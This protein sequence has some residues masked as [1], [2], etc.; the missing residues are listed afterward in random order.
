[1]NKKR[2]VSKIRETPF[3]KGVGMDKIEEFDKQKTK[4][5]KYIL[6]KKRSES[7]IRTKFSHIIDENMLEDI[8]EYLK[9]AGYINDLEFIEKMVEEYKRLKHL[10]IKELTY[11][12]YTKG[13]DRDLLYSYLEKNKDELEEYE[14]ESACYIRR[15]KENTMEEQEIESY[16]LKKGYQRESIK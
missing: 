9:E 2:G 1:M 3:V 14:K 7:E 11:K 15:K 12:L 5:L 10:S 8:I 16:L 6:Y 13:L 4:V